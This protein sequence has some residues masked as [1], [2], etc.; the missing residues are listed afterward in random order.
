MDYG[1]L[2]YE[3]LQFLTAYDFQ[4]QNNSNKKYIEIFCTKN[5]I[6]ITYHEWPQFADFYVLITSNIDEYKAHK[7]QRSYGLNWLLD[8]ISLKN[9]QNFNINK[10]SKIELFEVYVKQQIQ[11]RQEAFGVL[12]N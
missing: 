3:K 5:N 10:L 6:C 7:F 12:I 11:N 9:K 1:I 8:N 2:E 4:I